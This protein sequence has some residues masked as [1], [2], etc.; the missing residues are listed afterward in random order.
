MDGTGQSIP[1]VDIR[2]MRDRS[3]QRAGRTGHAR[4]SPFGRD[5]G[6]NQE[7]FTVKSLILA[8]DER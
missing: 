4:V 7:I 8:Q 1:D 6:Q 3:E 5:A 2:H